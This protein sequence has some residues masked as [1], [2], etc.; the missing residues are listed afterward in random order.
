MVVAVAAATEEEKARGK[1][2][3]IM[4]VEGKGQRA[5][6][7]AKEK[8]VGSGKFGFSSLDKHEPTRTNKQAIFDKCPSWFLGSC[9]SLILF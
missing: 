9:P 4:G 8:S 5:G 7:G 3:E 2:M 6:C 1:G